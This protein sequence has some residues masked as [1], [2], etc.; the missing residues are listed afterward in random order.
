MRYGSANCDFRSTSI[1]DVK[2]DDVTKTATI[3]G[4]G[5]LRMNN[6]DPPV[7]FTATAH[8]GGPRNS[9]MDTFTIDKCDGGGTV[10]HGDVKYTQDT[11]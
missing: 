10:V 5:N 4:L 1:T 9:G 7:P 6:D 11:H 3:T 8:D 2:W